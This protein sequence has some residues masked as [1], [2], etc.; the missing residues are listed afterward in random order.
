MERGTP[1]IL[2]VRL[3]AIGD[4]VRALPILHV[5]REAHHDA[6]ID[7]AVE[8]KSAAVLEGHPCLDRL[9][10]FDRP[11]EFKEGAKAFLAFCRQIR[12]TRYDIVLD[13]HGILK[14]GLITR[15][16]GA[17]RRIGFARPRAQEGS[18]LC[19][20]KRV[21]LDSPHLNRVEENLALVGAVVPK[22]RYPSVTLYVPPEVQE[23][24]EEYADETFDGGKCVVAVHAPVDRPEKQ[25]PL[26]HY[27]DLCD[28]LLSDGRFEV[29]L[30]WGPG[31]LEVA[32]EVAL[33]CRRTPIIAPETSDLKHYAWLVHQC[34]AYVGGDTGPMHIASAM[35]TPVV[36][37]FGGT[38]PRKHA[39]YRPP[40]RTL[41][42]APEEALTPGERLLRTTPEEVYDAV[43]DVLAEAHQIGRAEEADD[44]DEEYSGD[45]EE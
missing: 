18:W 38:D 32:Q 13:A 22:V 1:K 14:S 20:N 23:A 2:I 37:I 19:T 34:G 6:R 16:S 21:R 15:F 33:G 45:A 40:F 35:G 8:R 41:H 27:S 10:V 31:Q 24:V 9:L 39:P 29:L 28:L 30:T 12:S 42:A 36:A 4:V 43:I 7:W 17:K 25:W 5:L 11:E 26:S 3:S 44:P